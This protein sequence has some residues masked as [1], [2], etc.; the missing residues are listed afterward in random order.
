MLSFRKVGVIGSYQ[1]YFILFGAFWPPLEVCLHFIEFSHLLCLCQA[2]HDCLFYIKFGFFVCRFVRK[3][4]IGYPCIH[5]SD[6]QVR[7]VDMFE[8]LVDIAEVLLVYI[9]FLF[10]RLLLLLAFPARASALRLLNWGLLILSHLMLYVFELVFLYGSFLAH[11][12]D[13]TFG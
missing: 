10:G 6:F 12:V 11:D 4:G 2:I 9:I 3:V 7:K 13:E 8:N 1:Q 5:L